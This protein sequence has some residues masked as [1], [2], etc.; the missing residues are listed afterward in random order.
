MSDDRRRDQDYDPKRD[1]PG[2]GEDRDKDLGESSYP[3]KDGEDTIDW[4]RPIPDPDKDGG[5]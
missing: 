2:W 5:A 3:D 4:D 1:H